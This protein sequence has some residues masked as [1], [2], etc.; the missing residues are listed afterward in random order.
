MERLVIRVK[1]SKDGRM[2]EVRP[3]WKPVRRKKAR[4]AS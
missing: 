2:V 4:R 3:V 1:R